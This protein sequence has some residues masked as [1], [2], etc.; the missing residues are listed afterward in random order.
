MTALHSGTLL[1]PGK[2]VTFGAVNCADIVVRD[3]DL[4]AKLGL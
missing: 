1:L 4:R 3:R 2:R